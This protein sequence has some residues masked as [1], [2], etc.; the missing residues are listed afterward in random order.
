MLFLYV[1]AVPVG[2]SSRSVPARTVFMNF[3]KTGRLVLSP[4]RSVPYF[5]MGISPAE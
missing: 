5:W 2:N 3:L 4:S 1:G